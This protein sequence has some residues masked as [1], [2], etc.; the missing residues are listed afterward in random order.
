MNV[1][2]CRARRKEAVQY[3]DRKGVEVMNLVAVALGKDIEE[4]FAGDCVMWA[5]ARLVSFPR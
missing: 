5:R 3:W 4:Y 2:Y 1:I